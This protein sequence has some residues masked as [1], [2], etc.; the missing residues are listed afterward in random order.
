MPSP[1]V[2]SLSK[3]T[4]KSVAEIE[5][6][7][8]K[9]KEITADTF[10]KPED[11]FGSKEYKYTVGIVK[12]MLG[13]NENVLDPSI[14]LKSGKSAKEFIQE[15]VVSGSFSIGDENPVVNKNKEDDGEEKAN[16]ITM[17]NFPDEGGDLDEQVEIPQGSSDIGNI[18]T[19][20]S[21]N[22]QEDEVILPNESYY[23]E[24]DDY[25]DPQRVETNA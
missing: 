5:K 3:E 11:S 21:S 17:Q 22:A 2:N 7:W 13:I 8:N 10:G 23:A 16:D 9:A 1:Y 14:F 25:E 24:F 20:I 6:L 12:N 4:G 19:D 18:M 15:T